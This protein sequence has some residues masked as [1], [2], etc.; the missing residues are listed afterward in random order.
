MASNLRDIPG[1]NRRASSFRRKRSASTRSAPSILIDPRANL[2]DRGRPSRSPR[3]PALHDRRRRIKPVDLL[4]GSLVLVVVGFLG[5]KLWS[6]TRV[7]V[8]ITGVEDEGAIT[9]AHSGTLAVHIKVEPTSKLQDAT[10]TLDGAD[11]AGIAKQR[12]DGFDWTPDKPLTAGM[13]HLRLTVPRP[14]LPAA[15]FKWDFLVDAVPP[16]I[17]VGS[18]LHAPVGIDDPVSIKG[19]VDTDATLTA[20]GDEVTVG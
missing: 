17:N 4:L 9:F 11:L 13:H 14:I 10:L 15:H 16:Q 2:Y 20:N 1:A 5:L 7:D 8:R 12:K 6:A 18:T 3:R 19:R